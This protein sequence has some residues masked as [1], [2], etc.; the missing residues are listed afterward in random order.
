MVA[1]MLVCAIRAIERTVEQLQD[2]IAALFVQ[3]PDHLLFRI[4]RAPAR[5]WL[6]DYYASLVRI[7]PAGP[8]PLRFKSTAESL[9]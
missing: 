8:T 5:I 4:F 1:Q 3:H 6:R 2:K 7:D 9:P